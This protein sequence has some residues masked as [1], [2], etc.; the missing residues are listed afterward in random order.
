MLNLPFYTKNVM[1]SEFILIPLLKVSGVIVMD[2]ASF[3]NKIYLSIIAEAYGHKI[4]W[5]PK[6]SPDKNPIEHIWA[7]MKT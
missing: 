5:L 1:G 4:H 3:H 7:T 2:N 6:Y